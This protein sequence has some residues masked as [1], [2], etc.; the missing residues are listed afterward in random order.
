[1]ADRPPDDRRRGAV[2]GAMARG[3]TDRATRGRAGT[4]R[5]DRPAVSREVARGATPARASVDRAATGRR[6]TRARG[7]GGPR[8]DG[9]PRGRPATT[10]RGRTAL[11]FDRRPS[12]P[13]GPQDR[14]RPH[15]GLGPD[16]V[17]MARL[18]PGGR[19]GRGRIVVRGPDRTIDSGRVRGSDPGRID[20][21]TSVTTDPATNPGVLTIGPP[22]RD[23][24]TAADR[25]T[26]H[27]P[28]DRR[29]DARSADRP[30]APTPIDRSGP[31]P[32]AIAR[33]GGGRATARDGAAL[34]GGA[35]SR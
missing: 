23:A 35:R 32:A 12:G 29:L 17:A 22:A 18:V 2:R 4:G 33:R 13:R 20:A 15:P 9:P 10:G 7:Y 31:G 1:M 11:P 34:A 21:P 19:P 28:V 16:P 26:G 6:A 3:A 25:T 27:A 14:F 24:T 8:R 30:A 5:A